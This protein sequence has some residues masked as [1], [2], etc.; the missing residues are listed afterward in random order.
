MSANSELEIL[1]RQDDSKLSKSSVMYFNDKLIGDE[2]GACCKNCFAFAA[3]NA[4]ALVMDEIAEDGVCGLFV[5]GKNQGDK[6][7]VDKI[8]KRAAGYTDD[9]PTHCGSCEYFDSN[10]WRC[11]KVEGLIE[12]EACCNLWERK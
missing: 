3:P 9:G 5:H 7:H 10:G 8:P 2:R 4:C 11:A 12:P 1:E 6:I